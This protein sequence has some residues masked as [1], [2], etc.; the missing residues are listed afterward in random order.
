MTSILKLGARVDQQTI[1]IESDRKDYDDYA[2]SYL[3]A[4]N[5]MF[6]PN[7]KLSLVGHIK[8][9]YLWR[10]SF[11]PMVSILQPIPMSVAMKIS[12]SKSRIT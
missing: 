8:S 1:D 10:K 12:M 4:V 7:Y 6:A 9:V 5:W 2:V 3:G 11:M